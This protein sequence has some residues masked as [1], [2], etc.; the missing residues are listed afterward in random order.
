MLN[1]AA[2]REIS[3]TDAHCELDQTRLI[4]LAGTAMS[5]ISP[6]V[7]LLVAV[8]RFAN[9]VLGC[10]AFPQQGMVSSQYKDCFA[11]L[12]LRRFTILSEQSKAP[13][14]MRIRIR[15]P[16]RDLEFHLRSRSGFTPEHQPRTDLFGPFADA[17]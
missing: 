7:A 5:L 6:N 14:Y 2:G 17:R 11:V 8:H 12:A 3:G 10:D 4:L 1:V 9:L 13:L 16:G 15:D